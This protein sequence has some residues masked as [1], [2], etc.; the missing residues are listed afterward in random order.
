MSQGIASLHK[1]LKDEKRRRIIQLLNDRGNLSHSDLMDNLELASTGQLNYHLK[2]LGDLLE[3][4]EIGQYRL[5]EKGKLAYKVLTDFPN[6]QP[7]EQSYKRKR[8]IASILAIANAISL[9]VSSLLFF[10]GYINWHFFSSQMIYSFVAFLVAF[11]IFKFPTSRPKYDPK[12]ARKLTAASFVI[13]GAMFTSIF[14]F[15]VTGILL[16][17]IL[18]TRIPGGPIGTA[19]LLFSFVGGPIIGGIIGYYLSRRSKYSNPSFYSPF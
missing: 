1:I 5:S 4:N 11:I 17:T 3:K 18:G 6:G 9:I 14:L 2:I 16:M 19:F 8:L 13:G 15:F 7:M 10:I 12:R